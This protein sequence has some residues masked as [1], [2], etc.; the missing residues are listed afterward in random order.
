MY[1]GYSLAFMFE[2]FLGIRVAFQLGRN[3]APSG[4]FGSFVLHETSHVEEITA[5]EMVNCKATP[6]DNVFL[7]ISN[8]EPFQDGWPREPTTTEII[9][10]RCCLTMFWLFSVISLQHFLTLK[11]LN[12]QRQE[13]CSMKSTGSFVWKPST[14]HISGAIPAKVFVGK[15]TYP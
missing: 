6:R 9:T 3:T 1:A 8:C 4:G 11:I 7:K 15:L 13:F 5:E 12:A 2:W 14:R 10:P